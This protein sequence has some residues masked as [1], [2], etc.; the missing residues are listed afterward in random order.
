MFSHG[1]PRL[2]RSRMIF[3][4]VAASRISLASLSPYLIT[5]RPSP[6]DSAF[7]SADYCGDS[8]ALDL[9]VGR[10]SHIP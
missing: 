4:I 2:P 5:C 6:C 8:V 10:R 9:A 1:N 7:L 3:K